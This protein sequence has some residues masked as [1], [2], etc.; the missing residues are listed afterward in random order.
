LALTG[1]ELSAL[2]PKWFTTREKIPEFQCIGGDVS[3]KIGLDNL[4]KI[5]FYPSRPQTSTPVIY[6]ISSHYTDFATPLYMAVILL[7]FINLMIVSSGL[8]N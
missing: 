7:V 6:L 2:C 1:S 8:Q 3:T 4:E 5:I